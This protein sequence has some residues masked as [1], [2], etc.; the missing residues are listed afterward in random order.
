MCCLEPPLIKL[1]DFLNNLNCHC[2]C[3]CVR[4]GNAIQS[5]MKNVFN[6][7]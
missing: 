7:N 4:V 1:K 5:S 3:I 6:F 2:K